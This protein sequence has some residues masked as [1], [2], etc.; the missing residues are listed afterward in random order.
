MLLEL[1]E[2]YNT[3]KLRVNSFQ[4]DKKA[5]GKDEKTFEAHCLDSF[6][7]ACEKETIEVLDLK[8]G[9]ICSEP[10]TVGNVVINKRV[11]FM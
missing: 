8:T 11:V 2:G 5:K 9:E 10:K 1:Y 4:I 3:K 7:L 6:V